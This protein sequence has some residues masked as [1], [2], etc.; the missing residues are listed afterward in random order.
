MLRIKLS[1]CYLIALLIFTTCDDSISPEKE[2]K[3]EH[4]PE[5]VFINEGLSFTMGCLDLPGW[6]TVT[7]I[8]QPYFKVTLDPYYIGTYE[9]R[10]DE[11]N[12]FVK[13]GGYKDSTVWS[14]SG[15]VYIKKE[16]RERPVGWI[17]GENPWKNRTFSNTPDKPISYITWYETEAYCNWLSKKTG[18]SFTLPTEAQWERAAR[19]PDPGRQF[20]W[21]NE[22]DSSKY[23][24]FRY[25]GKLFAVGVYIEDKT[26]E[27]CYDMAGNL[28][29]FCLDLHD[30]AI[31]DKYKENEPVYNPKGPE[32]NY[33]G[34]R[35]LRGIYSYFHYKP[36]LEYQI[37]TYRRSPCG[38]AVNYID[39][40]FRIV[41]NIK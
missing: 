20:T 18:E 27:G 28:A 41:K 1:V 40:G 19:G 33:D 2:E 35:S 14:D 38:A 34:D 12:Y 29:E 4:I 13:G 9:I 32:S 3:F 15:W 25:S 23:N 6:F 22:H 11:F 7:G 26:Y 16:N 24:N 39:C 21:G 8:E 10:N 37:T 30:F 36:E 17:E 5:L 31:Y